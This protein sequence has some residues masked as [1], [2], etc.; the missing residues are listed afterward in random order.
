LADDELVEAIPE[1]FECETCE[2]R[3][4]LDSLASENAY[5]WSIFQQAYTRLAFDG[6]AFG[7]VVRRLTAH[8]SEDEFADLW[9][10]MNILYDVLVPPP[11][12]T[13]GA[14]D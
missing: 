10:R 2:V 7:E 4:R 12:R 3:E 11:A 5:A 14:A 9:G 8:L 13:K 6:N 1:D